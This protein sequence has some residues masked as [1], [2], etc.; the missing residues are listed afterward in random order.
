MIYKIFLVY[1]ALV[2]LVSVIVTCHDKLQAKQGGR[3][4]PEMTLLNLS[5]FGG[6]VA[7]YL[8]MKLIRHK[9]RHPRFMVGIPV[10]ILMQV[11]AVLSLMYLL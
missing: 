7:M 10:I 11:A 9:T 5:V 8:T 6:S 3:R 1:L 2:S 4:V